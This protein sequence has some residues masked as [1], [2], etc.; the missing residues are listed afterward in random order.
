MPTLQPVVRQGSAIPGSVCWQKV[1]LVGK[2]RD[3]RR[4]KVLVGYDMDEATRSRLVAVRRAFV[5]LSHSSWT[6]SRMGR[7]W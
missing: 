6:A 3:V 1:A 4:T 7:S 2:I 5:S